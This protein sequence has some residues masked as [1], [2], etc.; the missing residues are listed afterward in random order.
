MNKKILLIGVIL[1][2]AAILGVVL[3]AAGAGGG[4]G[5]NGTPTPSSTPSVLTPTAV[6][7]TRTTAPSPVP[8]RTPSPIGTPIPVETITI[9]ALEN[10]YRWEPRV[11]N[12]VSGEI[13]EI[14][15]VNDTDTAH[16]L[17]EPDYMHLDVYVLPHT[18]K[19]VTLKADSAWKTSFFY[20]RIHEG[21]SMNGN[22]VVG[23]K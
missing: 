11:I 7:S 21:A 3:F 15:V 1:V 22:I 9:R 19:S 4:S 20:C 14:E 23:S 18:K 8:G 6:P 17:V 2:A 16:W 5:E 13:Y 10:P 12:L